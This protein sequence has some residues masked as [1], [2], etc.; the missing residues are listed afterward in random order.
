MAV[1]MMERPEPAPV[2]PSTISFSMACR[3]VVMPALRQARITS[4]SDPVEPS[5]LNLAASN[6]TPRPS[7]T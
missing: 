2:A 4:F 5:Q 6:R 1:G 3:M 7:S